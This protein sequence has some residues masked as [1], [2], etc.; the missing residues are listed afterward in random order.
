MYSLAGY[1]VGMRVKTSIT[2]SRE[3]L[4]ALDELAQGRSRSE[5]IEQAVL[6]HIRR[7]ERDARSERERELLDA[8]ADAL[9]EEMADVLEYQADWDRATR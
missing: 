6:E 7:L 5:L 3:T 9:N 2:L 4:R 1:D 8:H